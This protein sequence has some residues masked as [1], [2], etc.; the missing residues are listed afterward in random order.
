M[1]HLNL[2]ACDAYVWDMATVAELNLL[3]ASVLQ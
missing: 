3:A 1:P 2:N